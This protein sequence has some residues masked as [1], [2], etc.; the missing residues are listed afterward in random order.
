MIR[1]FRR[2]E[3]Y[4]RAS[5]RLVNLIARPDVVVEMI[6][7]VPVAAEA[8]V[9]RA[10]VVLMAVHLHEEQQA[11]CNHERRVGYDRERRE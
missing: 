8:E 3:F 7:N 6:H 10:G 9:I 2:P 5:W 1:C 4:W 11:A